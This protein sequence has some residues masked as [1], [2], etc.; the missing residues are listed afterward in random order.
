MTIN[1]PCVGCV[2]LNLKRPWVI[3]CDI[4]SEHRSIGTFTAQLQSAPECV[5][6]KWT[7]IAR[8]S[9]G[10]SCR[11]EAKENVKGIEKMWRRCCLQKG[12]KEKNTYGKITL[13]EMTIFTKMLAALRRLHEFATEGFR[14]SWFHC[15]LVGGKTFSDQIGELKASNMD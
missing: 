12:K 15:G 10:F 7:N 14:R 9:A 8:H 3:S 11:R 5:Y 4:S 2:D 1:M 6:L 13:I